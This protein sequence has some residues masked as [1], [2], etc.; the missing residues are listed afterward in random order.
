MWVLGMVEMGAKVHRLEK[1]EQALGIKP[2][3]LAVPGTKQGRWETRLWAGES[4]VT[5]LQG[6]SLLFIT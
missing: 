5:C 1:Q 6:H 4:I 2:C 3:L